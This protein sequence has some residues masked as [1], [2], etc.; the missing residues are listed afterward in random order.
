MSPYR[1]VLGK[2]CHLLAELEHRDFWAMKTLNMDMAATGEKRLLQLNEM[3]EFRNEAYEN[4]KIYKEWTKDWHEKNLVRKE[5]QP[6]KMKSRWS[7]NYTVVKVFPYGAVEVTS[8]NTGNFKVNGKRLKLYLVDH[9]NQAKS[10]TLLT[11]K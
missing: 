11:P 9:F 3:E 5:F 7:G 1:L 2:V 6:C 4:A 8:E 10:V